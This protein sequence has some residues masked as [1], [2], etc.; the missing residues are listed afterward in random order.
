MSK[1]A[2][3]LRGSMP[4]V[5]KFRARFFRV[6]RPRK[7]TDW[8]IEVATAPFLRWQDAYGQQAGDA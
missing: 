2:A 8:L 3:F 4:M 1:P 6:F 7:M 5:E